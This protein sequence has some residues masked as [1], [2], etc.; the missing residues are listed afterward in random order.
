MSS[1]PY[2]A[3]TLVALAAVRE[4]AQLCHGVQQEIESSSIEKKD[5]S[6]VT[7]ADFGSQALVCS[8]LRA[9]FPNDPIIAEETSEALRSPDHPDRL[10]AVVSRVLAFRPDAQTEEILSWIDFGGHK[11]GEPRFWTLD[12]I[13]GTKGFLRGDQYAV[14]LA[15]V[16]GGMV[17]VAALACPNLPLPGSGQGKGSVSLAVRG[18]GT[19]LFRLSDMEPLGRAQVSAA[20][21]PARL[22]LCES[23]EAGHTSHSKSRR[24]ADI[25]GITAESVRLDSQAK[26]AVVASGAAEIYLRLPSGRRYVENIW[27]HAAGALIV[28]EAGGTVTDITGKS[29]S[30]DHGFQLRENRGVVVSNGPVHADLIKAI[31]EAGVA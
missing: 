27:D 14:A 26:Y 11:N 28:E 24:V 8:R 13:D 23:V 7:V 10:H 9:A 4:A 18:Q 19:M 1:N 30:F 31:A 22:R 29:L 15:L 2:E 16:V 5:R 6:P 21:D 20:T 3:E 25:V 12:P 17:V